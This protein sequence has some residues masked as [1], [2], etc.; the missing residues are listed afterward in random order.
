MGYRMRPVVWFTLAFLLALV[1]VACGGD[2][3]KDEE[4][5]DAPSPTPESVD[6]SET[7]ECTR[8][9]G[10][11]G[12]AVTFALKHPAGWTASCNAFIQVKNV[13]YSGSPPAGAM[14]MTVTINQFLENSPTN[15]IEAVHG[16]MTGPD[17]EV[18][19]SEI[20]GQPAAI[21]YFDLGGEPGLE[22]A[23]TIDE[24]WL[25]FAALYTAKDELATF[26]P[27]ALEI[28]NTF[29]VIS[30]DDIEQ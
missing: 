29:E 14:R 24:E 26:E 1:V 19:E 15:V 23:L 12:K 7:V 4:K 18:I 20:N 30:I 9:F 3:D 11:A 8:E 17:G 10:F 28:M 16:G 21:G 6:L 22:I 5:R 27:L 13:D 2:D 25:A